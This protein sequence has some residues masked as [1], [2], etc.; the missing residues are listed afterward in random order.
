MTKSDCVILVMDIDLRSSIRSSIKKE[1]DL[2]G[3]FDILVQ[4]SSAGEM[5]REES[6]ALFIDGFQT[7]SRG[8]IERNGTTIAR[9]VT[10][11]ITC[12][13][14]REIFQIKFGNSYW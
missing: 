9:Q 3:I 10:W 6:I 1:D 2:M 5:R 14:L 4:L 7:L 8:S 13:K 11:W 12:G